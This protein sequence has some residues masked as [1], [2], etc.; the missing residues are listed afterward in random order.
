MKEYDVWFKKAAASR[1]VYVWIR[2]AENRIAAIESAEKALKEEY[3]GD[4]IL[5]DVVEKERVA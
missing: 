2:F 4:A 1:K 5:F 3:F